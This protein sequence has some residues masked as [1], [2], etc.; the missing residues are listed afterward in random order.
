M[1]RNLIVGDIHGCLS[2]LE[3]ALENAN[4]DI[5]ND[6]LYSLGDLTDRGEENVNLLYYLMSLP[7]FNMVIGNHDL[8]LLDYLLNGNIDS[9]WYKNGGYITIDEFDKRNIT[10]EEKKRIGE[11]LRKFPA[12][13]STDNALIMHGGPYIFS[14]EQ[15]ERYA[16]EIITPEDPYDFECPT[17]SVIWDRQY[18]KAAAQGYDVFLDTPKKIFIGHTPVLKPVYYKK[19][20]LILLDTSINKMKGYITVMDMDTLEFWTSLGSKKYKL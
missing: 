9:D 8:W 3:K 18:L 11:W 1:N 12:I 6:N 16:L 15:L 5:L 19:S 13:I 17:Y 10:N 2:K 7:N 4:F 14:R 20:N